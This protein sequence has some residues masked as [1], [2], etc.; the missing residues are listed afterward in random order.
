M[1]HSEVKAVDVYGCS[2]ALTPDARIAPAVIRVTDGKVASIEPDDGSGAGATVL[3][4][5]VVPGFVDLQVNGFGPRDVTECT[6]EA[7]TAIATA[8]L[9]RGVTAWCPTI[10]STS[11]D[12]R[13][14]ALDAIADAR[15]AG[16]GARILGAHLE[17]P[18]LS[19]VRAGAHDPSVLETPTAAAVAR[20]IER[21]DG[22]VRIVTLAPELEG[23]LDAIA[24]LAGAGVVAS[25]GH[26][27][28]TL[29]EERAGIDAGAT[30]VTH[31]FNAMRPLHHREPGIIGA[32][33]AD[34]R[35]TCGL[36]GDGTHVH[37][38]LVAFT[39]RAR[40][41]NVALVSD[42]VS[43]EGDKV[44]KLP[45]GTIAGS[46]CALDEGIRVAAAAGAE[47][48]TV[49]AAATRTPSSLMGEPCGRLEPGAPADFVVLANDLRPT[50]TYVGGKL[51][52]SAHA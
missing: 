29:S 11:E 13:L 22:L 37:P 34:D 47:V 36:I 31:L 18:W 7:I 17:G 6:P 24:E 52:W 27:D 42:V 49:I 30:M 2:A 20:S 33:L 23:G 41:N 39:L 5:T 51:V 43:G 45:D 10:I 44:A 35:V 50:A 25:L 26:T 15:K 1:I 4:G 46:L 21:Q 40:P 38:S 3:K 16:A 9:A 14:R 48:A 19:P 8:L 28:A 32:A 12:V